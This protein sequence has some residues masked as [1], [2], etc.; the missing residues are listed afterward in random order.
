MPGSFAAPH[1]AQT[2]LRDAPQAPQK[3]APAGFSVEQ[4]GQ[5]FTAKSVDR[6]GAAA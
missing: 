5:T 4:L 1:E 2:R 3:R 6:Y